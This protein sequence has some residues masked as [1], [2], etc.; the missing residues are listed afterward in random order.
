MSITKAQVVQY[1]AVASVVVPFGDV[2]TG[3]A[4]A[5]CQVPAGSIV[6]GGEVVVTTAYDSATSA[7]LDLG[8]GGDPNRYTSSPVDIKAAG[9]TALTLTGYDYTETDDVEATITLT[10]ATAAGSVTINVMYV[11][12]GRGHEVQG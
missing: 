11:V 3:V 6:V 8:D 1:P 12:A 5:V 2:E 10:G 7:A 4:N 9:L